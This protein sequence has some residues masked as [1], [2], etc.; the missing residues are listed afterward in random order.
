[1]DKKKD[2]KTFPINVTVLRMYE[3]GYSMEDIVAATGLTAK[4]N[5]RQTL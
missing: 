3:A 4:K 1:M 5:K 2:H